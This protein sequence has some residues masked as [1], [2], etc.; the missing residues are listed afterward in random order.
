M[1]R[2]L[3]SLLALSLLAPAAMAAGAPTV[4]PF[5]L[6]GDHVEIPVTINGQPMRALLDSGASATEMDSALAQRLSLVSRRLTAAMKADATGVITLAPSP[7]P[8]MVGLPDG[9]LQPGLVVVGGWKSP[10]PVYTADL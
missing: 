1:A 5:E 8:A 9:I 10:E 6:V 2:F 3:L 4:I 7:T